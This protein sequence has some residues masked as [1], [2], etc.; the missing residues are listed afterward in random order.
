MTNERS[1]GDARKSLYLRLFSKGHL[2]PMSFRQGQAV[3]DGALSPARWEATLRKTRIVQE[4][5]MT[6]ASPRTATIS[7]MEI[8]RDRLREAP[9]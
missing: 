5:P 1:C 7:K 9:R 3:L 8:A 6:S 2:G 4:R